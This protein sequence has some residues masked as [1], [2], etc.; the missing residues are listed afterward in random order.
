MQQPCCP[1]APG[2]RAGRGS[3]AWGPHRAGSCH[4]LRSQGH[5]W[6]PVTA[7]GLA[8]EEQVKPQEPCQQLQSPAE[9]PGRCR[10]PARS[11][12]HKVPVLTTPTGSLATSTHIRGVTVGQCARGAS[13][14]DHP[15]A[16]GHSGPA[17]E[18]WGPSAVCT[19]GTAVQGT[20]GP[21][22]VQPHLRGEGIASR[23][24]CQC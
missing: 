19:Q 13:S 17:S 11:C 15:T 9:G 20:L 10:W 2:R 5:A 18:Y 6:G 23:E 12:Q 24:S 8:Q 21:L 3:R 16:S 1:G 14:T 4:K 7:C 22:Q